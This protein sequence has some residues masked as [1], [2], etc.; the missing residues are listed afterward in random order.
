MGYNP[1]ADWTD[2]PSPIPQVA[3]R[4]EQFKQAQKHAQELMIK[5]QK[6]WVKHKDTPKYQVGDQVWLEGRHLHTNQPTTK[7]APR[8]HG[9]FKVIQVMSDVNYRL[10]L[11]TQWSIHPVFH[12]DLLTPYRETPT[13]GRNYQRPPLELVDREEEYEVEKILDQWQFSRRRKLQYL[14][15]W[16]GYSDS[17]NQWVDSTDV[18]ADEA[19]REFQNSNPAS[20]IHKSKHKSHRNRHLLSSLTYMTS[21]SPLPIPPR[22]ANDNSLDARA[23]NYSISRIFGMLIEPECGRVSPDFIEYQDTADTGVEGSDDQVEAGTTRESPTALEVPVRIPSTSDIAEV[24]NH[25]YDPLSPN[26]PSEY[27]HDEYDGQFHFVPEEHARQ[28]HAQVAREAAVATT[29]EANHMPLTPYVVTDTEEHDSNKEN[30]N[31]N[32]EDGEDA[33]EISRSRQDA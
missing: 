10:E 32:Q 21:L 29:W 17:E 3:L 27:H 18:F 12:T 6:S 11:P 30:R 9:P 8:R 13:H 15:K 25:P 24:H 7:L 14:V 1:R 20:S 28:V 33:E 4:L 31:P 5:A 2:R 22:D 16:K 23:T 26:L 19:I